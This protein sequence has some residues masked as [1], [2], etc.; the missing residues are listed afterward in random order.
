M[1]PGT[2]RLC[3]WMPLNVRNK[4]IYG[5]WDISLQWNEGAGHTPGDPRSMSLNVSHHKEHQYIRIKG[6][7]FE[8]FSLLTIQLPMWPNLTLTNVIPG[9]SFIKTMMGPGPRCYIPSF[10]KIGITFPEK[11]I[12]EGAGHIKMIGSFKL[13][14]F[15]NGLQL[16]FLPGIAIC[17]VERHLV[18]CPTT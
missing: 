12:F 13:N 3:H 6:W 18:N 15:K 1:T 10:M 7:L 4:N 11:K 5:F 16:C 9:S 8:R 2:K 17:N 14:C